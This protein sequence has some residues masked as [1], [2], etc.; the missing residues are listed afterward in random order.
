MP[1]APKRKVSNTTSDKDV[2]LVKSKKH[3]YYVAN[4]DKL[5]AKQKEYVKLNKEKIKE[6]KRKWHLE[7]Q[8]KIVKKATKW[9]REHPERRLEIRAKYRDNNRDLLNSKNQKYRMKN[10][11]IVLDHYSNGTDSCSCC[12]EDIYQFLTIDHINGGGNAHR[13]KTKVRGGHHFYYWLIK[14]G[15]P[16]G[17]QVLCFNCNM[18]KGFFGVCPHTLSTL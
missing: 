11:R 9:N 7:N 16:K 15:F 13:K 10:R 5:L 14:N 1:Q 17:Y 3:A 2:A 12:G 18:S 4:K 8:D 6:Y